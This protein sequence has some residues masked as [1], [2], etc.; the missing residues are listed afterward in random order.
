[1]TVLVTCPQERYHILIL[2]N[3]HR[4]FVGAPEVGRLLLFRVRYDF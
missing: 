2:N 3:L 4:E 1:M